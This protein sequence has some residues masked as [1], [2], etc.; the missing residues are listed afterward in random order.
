MFSGESEGSK[1]ADMKKRNKTKALTMNSSFKFEGDS[2]C[3]PGSPMTNCGYR[4]KFSWIVI[5]FSIL[6]LK[7]IPCQ[8]QS[9]ID[10]SF[11]FIWNVS[12]QYWKS[13]M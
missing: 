13:N 7:K 5:S 10:Y 3:F 2:S 9:M 4:D 11:E 1:E 8:E 6:V 12:V